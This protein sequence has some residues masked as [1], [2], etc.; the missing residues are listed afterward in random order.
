MRRNSHYL[1][2]IISIVLL[3]SVNILFAAPPS[4]YTST[5]SDE[6]NSISLDTD[7][8]GSPTWAPWWVTW[9]VHYLDG[10]SDDCYKTCNE[11]L[12][13]NVNLHYT[14]NGV[15]N[16]I[17][18]K[19]SNV[20][21]NTNQLD[22][23]QY[24][25][26]MISADKSYSQLYGYWE[27]R[28]KLT[29]SQ[30]HHWAMWL[31][32]DDASW[33]PEIDMVEVVGHQPNMIHMNS[34][35][36]SNDV[37]VTI[38]DVDPRNYVTYGF[39]WTPSTM[40]WYINGVVRK[41]IPNYVNKPMYWLLSPEMAN[42][43][44]GDP[45]GST[46]WPMKAEVDYLRV[47]EY[48][49]SSS[50]GGDISVRARAVGSTGGRLQL[51]IDD[52]TE[53]TWTLNSTSYQTFTHT[54]SVSS[55]NVKVLF[56][57]NSGDAQID[58]I[59]AGGSTYQ[60]EN[61]ATNTSVWQDGSCGGSYSELMHCYGY[62]DFGTLSLGGSTPTNNPPSV[63]I[64]SPSNGATYTES[65]NITINANASD[66]D[67]SV[68]KVEFYRGST[69]IGE[70]ASSPYS[71]TWYNAS[72]GSVTLTA[73]ATDDDG[74]STTSSGVNVTVNAASSGGGDIVVRAK[75][76]NAT[77]CQLELLLDGAVKTTWTLNST[78]YQNY[79]YTSSLSSAN[80][81]VAF[82]DPNGNADAQIDYL[83]ASGSTYQA[84]D[85]ATNTA[86]WQDGS[87]GGS[88]SELMHCAGGRYI[89]FGTVNIG[90]SGGG[91]NTGPN[92]KI[93]AEDFDAQ[94]GGINAWSSIGGI[95]AGEWVRYD[96]VDLGNG[97]GTFRINYCK[98]GAYL[99]TV[100]VR[101]DGTNG[102][103]IG[104]FET[105]DTG[106]WS[107][108][109]YDEMTTSLTGGTG[110]HDV[111]VV[112][113]DGGAG[114]F[115]WW[116]FENGLAKSIEEPC[117]PCMNSP[118]AFA[119][120]QNYPNPFNPYTQIRYWLPSEG[121]VQ[122]QVFNIQGALINDLVEDVKP[123]GY[124]TVQWNATDQSGHKVPSGFYLYRVNFYAQDKTY[125]ETKK[126]LLVK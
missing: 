50:G 28:M 35:G 61:Q 123:A 108:T 69:K 57:D 67:G 125:T 60:A 116:Q 4:G 78:A 111:Y 70:D 8:N 62:I 32:A 19:A 44:T 73:K 98:G 113:Q 36:S 34:H 100:E 106:G 95:D 84:E 16:L 29:V 25:G 112:F 120:D 3:F 115:D 92:I 63:S 9:N 49:G 81:K 14:S 105:T 74:A 89:D 1:N 59:E 43:W 37:M 33:P 52:V 31:L 26:G 77:G 119:V 42:S 114:N 99:S 71:V 96:D 6:F 51:K 72:E 48:T 65:D 55:A 15:L 30:G 11:W 21:V 24:L 7:G 110:V 126:M 46:V 94:S 101:L 87:C 17:G 97:Y 39:E 38:T 86:V 103:K 75:A 2:I 83:Q 18:Q 5:F 58:Y 66:S 88:Y 27:C 54:A 45:D 76:L 80:I 118:K 91:S 20:G 117:I 53:A 68:S 23:K 124:Y 82:Q 13:E 64:T 122:V 41:E 109:D 107:S 90:G 12:N 85:Q 79:S 93:E 22:G 121:L 40:K 47:Y 10:N 102:T 56:E 104:E